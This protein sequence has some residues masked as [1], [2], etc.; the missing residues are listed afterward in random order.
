VVVTLAKQCVVSEIPCEQCGAEMVLLAKK[1][2]NGEIINWWSCVEF[3]M[4]YQHVAPY[5]PKVFE[6]E[7]SGWSQ[8]YVFE[9]KDIAERFAQKFISEGFVSEYKIIEKVGA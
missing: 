4:Q 8:N 9:C 5:E 6:V 1:V 7:L 3:G 2:A